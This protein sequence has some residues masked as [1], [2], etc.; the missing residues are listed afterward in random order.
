MSQNGGFLT[1]LRRQAPGCDIAWALAFKAVALVILY[2]AFFGPSR[3]V[4]VTPD[5]AAAAL[6]HPAQSS[7]RR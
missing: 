4:A 7:E 1:A 3:Q 2:V 6:V 5:R